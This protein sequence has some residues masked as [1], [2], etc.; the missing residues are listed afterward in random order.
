[1]VGDG[2]I[3]SLNLISHF[4]VKL[5]KKKIID[6]TNSIHFGNLKPFSPRKI[7]TLLGRVTI[8]L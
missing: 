5:F 3:L 2:C 1:M 6:G 7:S 4:Q 8:F